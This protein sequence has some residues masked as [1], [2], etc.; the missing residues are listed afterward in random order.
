[1]FVSSVNR[2]NSLVLALFTCFFFLA[3]I[4]ALVSVFAENNMGI[5]L[6]LTPIMV[7]FVGT[8]LGFR[9]LHIIEGLDEHI[10]RFRVYA[11]SFYS[12]KQIKNNDLRPLIKTRNFLILLDSTFCP[13]I[14]PRLW[15]DYPEQTKRYKMTLEGSRLAL[16]EN[17]L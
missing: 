14:V 8:Y 13:L 17:Q 15:T 10:V 4:W 11:K 1:M 2:W 9:S 7:I 3:L 6:S 16:I 5:F 12:T